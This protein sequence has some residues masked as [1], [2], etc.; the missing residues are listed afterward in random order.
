MEMALVIRIT[1]NIASNF[2]REGLHDDNPGFS[3]FRQKSRKDYLP[4]Y[5]YLKD[6]AQEQHDLRVQTHWSHQEHRLGYVKNN[7]IVMGYQNTSEGSTLTN[8]LSL[9]RQIN[10]AIVQKFFQSLGITI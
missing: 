8:R 7:D 2:T 3:S 4:P 1:S 10:L 9:P 6:N 5:V